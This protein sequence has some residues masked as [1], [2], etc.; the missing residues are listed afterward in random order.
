M[1]AMVAVFSRPITTLE[2]TRKGGNMRKRIPIIDLFAGP[3]GL[4]EGFSSLTDPDGERVFQILMSVEMETS[5]HRTLRLRS[6]FRKIYDAEGRIPQQYLDYLENPTAAQLSKLQNT[7][8]TQWSEADHEAVQA[9]LVEGDNTL[10]REALKRLEGYNGPKIIIGGPPC[11]AYSLV[12]RSRRA[13]D[14]DLQKDEK[15][16]LYKCYLQFLN[17]IKPDVFVM[18][19]VK[20]ILSAQ[21]HSEGVLGMIRADIEEA[22]YTIH[23]LTTPNPQKP[24]DYVVKAERY[25]IP[26][27][28]HRVVLLGI[29]N[30]LAVETAQLKL[31]PEETVQDALAGIPPLRSDFSHRSKELEHT[32][33]ADYVLKAARRIAKHYPNTELANKLAKITRNSLPAFTSDDCVNNPDD[34]NSLTEWYRKRLNAVNSRILT[35]HVSRS[36]MAKDLDRYLF[37]AAFAQVHDQPA[38]LK[39]FPIYLLPAHKNVT[40]STNLKDVEFSDRFRVQLYNHPSTTVTSHISKD[41][42]YFIHPDYKQCRSLTVRE[43][44]RLQTF[45][46][47]Y[48]F[49]GNRTSQYQQVGNAVPPLLANQIA[50]VVAQCLHAPAEDYFDHLQHVWKKVRITK[51]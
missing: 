30:D 46:D 39:D 43:A 36:H 7:F 21:L 5:A 35:N 24:S 25:G 11:Q 16:T 19:N 18:E 28:R 6:F 31:H 23:S 1:A 45:P 48:F 12:G 29:R 38:K 41:G 10:V 14:P 9:K 32:S 51:Q 44:A 33:W 50:K 40:N 22:G 34:F 37:C 2:N 27:A 3:G 47:D 4:G 49:E 42:H 13:H 15:Q 8:P 17:A 26:Q 20:G